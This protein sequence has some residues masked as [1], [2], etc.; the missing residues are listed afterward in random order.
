MANNKNPSPKVFNLDQGPNFYDDGLSQ[1]DNQP[2]ILNLE[3][4]KKMFFQ[5]IPDELVYERDSSWAVIASPGRNLALYHYTG[6]ETTLPLNLSFYS[7]Q[8]NR[9]DVLGKCK[10]L[11]SLT[12]NDGY[13]KKPPRLKIIFGDMLRDS[14]WILY[15]F[16]PSYK[17][18][19]RPNGMMPQLATVELVFKKV[20]QENTTRAEVLTITT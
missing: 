6:G 18:F 15:S 2:F 20:S 12:M 11:E 9:Q 19:S 16:K 1:K 5:N 4:Y 17:M 10:W 13:S 14:T 7:N 3:D 8:E